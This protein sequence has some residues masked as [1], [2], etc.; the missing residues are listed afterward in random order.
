MQYK[1]RSVTFQ[2]LLV[3]RWNSLVTRC[4]ITPYSLQNSLITLWKI[5]SLLVVD[6][7]HCK[8]PLCTY[9]L[10][11]SLLTRCRSCSLQK[12]FVAHCKIHS[13]LLQK[14]LVAKNHSL[15]VPY[16]LVAKNH[17]LPVAKFT[18]YSLQK[19]LVKNHSL[20][21]VKFACYSL[22]KLF[23]A[24]RTRYSLQ[25][26]L[27]TCCRSCLL[28]ET[29]RYLL[30]NLLVT[31]CRSWSVLEILV[32]CSK[33]CLLR[34]AEVARCKRSLV[35]C[36]IRSLLVAE[37]ARCKKSLAVKNHWLLIAKFNRDLLHK[38]TKKSQL[39]LVMTDK[40]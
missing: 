34:V 23:V 19:L 24:K 21:V 13:L 15:P 36:K 29:T 31:R 9:L 2:S 12:F 28:Q 30:Q 37:V 6:V 20:L 4:K 25:N 35:T 10:Q 7:A 33:I 3:T 26:L 18:R 14:F 22:Q 8:T 32:I 39:N 11:N 40:I 5:H 27:V 1:T 17:S 16:S 38:V